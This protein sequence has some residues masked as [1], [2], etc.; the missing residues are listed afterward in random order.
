MSIYSVRDALLASK[1]TIAFTG[2][3]ISV[4]SGIPDFRSREGLWVKY[5]VEEYGTLEAFESDPEKF[6]RFYAEVQALH[7]SAMPNP[8]HRALA[9]LERLGL[10]QQVVTQNVDGLHEAA[11]HTEVVTLHGGP[12]RFTCLTC[13]ARRAAR[14]GEALPRCEV[15]SSILKPDVV[16]FGEALPL[17]PLERAQELAAACEVC[18]VVGT[19]AAVY[20]AA[21]IPEVALDQGALVC[22]FDLEGTTLTHSGRVRFFIGGPAEETL[23]RLVGLLEAELEAAR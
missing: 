1:H 11:G 5:P 2:A 17:A 4:P 21:S 10:L 14:H 15:C 7:G 19:S 12:G 22:Q 23:P 20:P 13:A 8:A 18:L 16:L 6:W 9:Q 3:G